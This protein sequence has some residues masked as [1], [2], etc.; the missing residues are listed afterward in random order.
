[1][2]Q[3]SRSKVS[4]LL[5]TEIEFAD[6]PPSA[7]SASHSPRTPVS[8]FSHIR[9]SNPASPAHQSGFPELIAES[10]S[11]GNDPFSVDRV[12]TPDIDPFARESRVFDSD[13]D[14]RSLTPTPHVFA[15]KSSISTYTFPPQSPSRAASRAASIS[16]K[17]ATA[18]ST[19]ESPRLVRSKY[20]PPPFPPPSH[21]PPRYPPPVR[22][23]P[24]TPSPKNHRSG[25]PDW[26]LGLDSPTG[27]HFRDA[28]FSKA[29]NEE[30]VE[31]SS[32][33]LMRLI[34]PRNRPSSPFPLLKS[35][36]SS[37]SLLQALAP[38]VTYRSRSN[39]SYS[40]D[41]SDDSQFQKHRPS[42]AKED[43][44]DSSNT[45]ATLRARP[46]FPHKPRTMTLPLTPTV[47]LSPRPDYTVSPLTP[48]HEFDVAKEDSSPI[49]PAVWRSSVPR[50]NVDGD[51]S[52]F[53]RVSG[54]TRDSFISTISDR[55]SFHTAISRMSTLSVDDMSQNTIDSWNDVRAISSSGDWDIWV[56]GPEG[57]LEGEEDGQVK[58]VSNT[59]GDLMEFCLVHD[60]VVVRKRSI[61]GDDEVTVLNVE[62]IEI[63]GG[64]LE[65]VLTL[66][67]SRMKVETTSRVEGISTVLAFSSPLP[68]TLGLLA[69]HCRGACVGQGVGDSDDSIT[70]VY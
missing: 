11:H 4:L 29:R 62:V 21:P 3:R 2:A 58:L 33:P 68:T 49:Q 51:W 46:L 34:S 23:L 67:R 37:K 63:R 8:P 9:P 66:A 53:A 31:S 50:N 12:L 32:K 30:K 44:S 43:S 36:S 20:V 22:P 6:S 47:P 7:T 65:M 10:N 35:S 1:M 56:R 61:P 55:A 38:S 57:Y 16:E 59:W 40:A 45:S 39:T 52:P 14:Q 54:D 17:T 25:S 19:E 13:A 5:D 24:P 69:N 60:G 15:E 70:R 18:K 42:V 41:L 48:H 28:P 64:G 27:A 26:T